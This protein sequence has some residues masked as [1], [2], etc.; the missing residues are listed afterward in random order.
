MSEQRAVYPPSRTQSDSDRQK[1]VE[2]E[3][4]EETKTFLFQYLSSR[5]RVDKDVP[6]SDAEVIEE[7]GQRAVRSCRT[8]GGGQAVI[9]GTRLAELGEF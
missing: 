4:E 5:V 7:H 1:A 3:E 6:I 8:E 9:V 2:T